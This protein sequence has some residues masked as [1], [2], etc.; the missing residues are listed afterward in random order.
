MG[1]KGKRVLVM[2]ARSLG[3]ILA[4]DILSKSRYNEQCPSDEVKSKC[5]ELGL[6]TQWHIERRDFEEFLILAFKPDPEVPGVFMLLLKFGTGDLGICIYNRY[7]GTF[8]EEPM[9]LEG[10]GITEENLKKI[11]FIHL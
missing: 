10:Y 7:T 2:G 8:I 9:G 5:F 1:T 11:N 3:A 4:R 6:G